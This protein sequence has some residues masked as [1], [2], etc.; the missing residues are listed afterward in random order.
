MKKAFLG[1]FLIA[2]MIT[3][4]V[5]VG[6]THFGAAQSNTQAGGATSPPP[7]LAPV[8]SDTFYS[9]YNLIDNIGTNLLQYPSV[10]DGYLWIVQS[11]AVGS[12][13][14][15]IMQCS[16]TR[17]AVLRSAP[18]NNSAAEVYAAYVLDGLV[19]VPGEKQNSPADTAIVVILNE[20]NLE[21]V[22]IISLN[23]IHNIPQI[24]YDSQRGLLE[25]GAVTVIYSP[26]T[27]ELGIYTVPPSESTVAADY[28][29]VPI[30]PDPVS[31]G[32][33]ECQVEDFNGS[34]W[35]S[36]VSPA[37]GAPGNVE[38]LLYSSSDLST[39]TLQF[40]CNMTNVGSAY[41]PHL[42]ASDSYLAFG[43]MSNASTGLST[44]RIEYI[45]THGGWSEYNSEIVANSG[46]DHPTISALS[47]NIFLWEPC[48]RYN[49][50]P[51]A[52]Y[53]FN[54]SSGAATFLFTVPN[55]TGG[56]DRWIG[57]DAA[58]RVL[59]VADCYGPS[60]LSSQIIRI[61]WNLPLTNYL[62]FPSTPTPSPTPT[63]TPTPT[64]VPATTGNGSTV[65][66]TITGNITSSQMSNVTITT[67]QSVNTT[68]L[69]FT[70]TG[71]NGTMGFSNVTIPIS[72]VPY[73]TSPTIYIDGQI[74]QNQGYTQDANNYYVWY[75]THFSTHQI[76]IV[77][78]ATSASH[79]SAI[80]SS[81]FQVIYGVA[82]AVVIVAIVVV[83]LMLLINGKKGKSSLENR[84]HVADFSE[85]L[86]NGV[87]E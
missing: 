68:T 29:W 76:S 69:S 71:E 1:V 49:V 61:N 85:G 16:L 36:A 44:Y 75:T 22:A 17:N 30:A 13:V 3:G 79:N 33:A 31:Y 73:G 42:T 50:L 47:S 35:V 78:T 20:T 83:A 60:G 15:T 65:N 67:N 34:V 45:G 48:T 54:A 24:I 84:E 4:A 43:V 87:K 51:H 25:L 59:Y 41:F 64:T 52:I 55:S 23:N 18:L 21:Q 63:P 86:D 66:L 6:T 72:A 74:A 32:S 2:I 40:S 81:L 14:P 39:W 5:F 38:T 19:Y 28:T 7:A 37:S 9:S 80:K 62:A 10:Y 57:V 11:H 8:S 27:G 46:Q 26:F 82:A 77:F 70:V 53:V 58:N 56:N 12:G